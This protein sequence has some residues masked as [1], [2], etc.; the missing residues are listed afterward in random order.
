M[1]SK[2]TS[3]TKREP[4][5]LTLMAQRRVFILLLWML[6]YHLSSQALLKACI[7]VRFRPVYRLHRA[8]AL[9]CRHPLPLPLFLIPAPYETDTTVC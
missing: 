9:V 6:L 1:L 5:Q 7:L 4:Q 2:R 3:R 8:L